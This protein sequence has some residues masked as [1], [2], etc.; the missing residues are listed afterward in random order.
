[1][2]DQ[3]VLLRWFVKRS[4]AAEDTKAQALGE[5]KVDAAASKSCV[6]ISEARGGWAL[7]GPM[8]ASEAV[9]FLISVMVAMG[10]PTRWVFMDRLVLLK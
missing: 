8:T 1:M 2:V 3:A 5:K 9:L 10:S 6:D 4:V 7:T